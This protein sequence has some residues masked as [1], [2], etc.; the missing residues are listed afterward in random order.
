MQVVECGPRDGLQNEQVVLGWQDKLRFVE[1]LADAGC[2]RIEAGAFVSPRLVPQMANSD[3][4]FLA[5]RD[6]G[7]LELSALVPNRRGL[8]RAAACGVR[9]IALFSAATDEFCRANI[10]M[11]V[12]ESLATYQDVAGAALELGMRVRG[13][14]SVAFGCPYSGAVQP[15]AVADVAARL[16]AMGCFEVS[17]ADTI[18]SATPE[19]V[20]Q[21]LTA[22]V[23]V[24]GLDQTALHLHDT[25]GRAIENLLVALGM[26]VRV[27]D[28]AA[29]GLGG[30][31]FAP[32]APGNVATEHVVVAL[33]QHGFATGIDVTAVASA[34][35]WARDRL[36]VRSDH[37]AG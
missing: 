14:V 7:D 27:F 20:S 30:C 3:E 28:A 37:A 2:G 29:A 10:G 4:L 33:E 1:L 13:Y 12:D 31:P 21:V 9:E 5:L 26:G 18:G 19:L 25:H 8:D 11:S 16:R 24:I 23:P 17:V 6:R 22:A 35:A 34:G 32:G 36:A 15:S